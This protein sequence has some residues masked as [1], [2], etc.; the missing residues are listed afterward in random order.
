M[1]EFGQTGSTQSSLQTPLSG[2]LSSSARPVEYPPPASSDL[3]LDTNG[4]LFRPATTPLASV[5]GVPQISI[6]H[7]RN[8]QVLSYSP[9]NHKLLAV[10]L[11][12]H[13]NEH[14][15]LVWDTERLKA[16]S[17]PIDPSK[18]LRDSSH[19][20]LDR[21]LVEFSDPLEARSD[22]PVGVY[23]FQ[24]SVSS[25]AWLASSQSQL[26]VGGLAAS[27]R[28]LH[29]YDI[30]QT[31]HVTRFETSAVFGL[32]ADPFDPY[33]FASHSSQGD[34]QIWDIRYGLRGVL[35][36]PLLSEG[37]STMRKIA[38]SPHRRGVL[39]SLGTD[40]DSIRLNC[41]QTMAL[42]L[43]GTLENPASSAGPSVDTFLWRTRHIRTDPPAPLA[44]FTW[45]PHLTPFAH[46]YRILTVN[47][48][49]HLE[50]R[51]IEELPRVAWDPHGS[52]AVADEQFSKIFDLQAPP[53]A[54]GL[55][56]AAS[57]MTLGQRWDM[58][59][60]P[61][62]TRDNRLISILEADVSM[63]M[64]RRAEQGYAMDPATNLKLIAHDRPLREAWSWIQDAV[65]LAEDS[66]FIAGNIRLGF[67]GIQKVLRELNKR[68][69]M[70][71]K[72]KQQQ[73]QLQHA[74]YDMTGGGPGGGGEDPIY[75]GS[76]LDIPRKLALRIS[77]CHFSQSRLEE[78]LLTMEKA[79]EFEKAAAWALFHNC[80]ERCVV[81]LSKSGIIA[82]A[83]SAHA[84]RV[85]DRSNQ[86]Y[87]DEWKQMNRRFMKSTDNSYLRAI[88]KYYYSED[89]SD[90]LNEQG[91]SMKERLSIALRFLDD[92][93]L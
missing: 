61:L 38:F 73:Q 9:H 54:E 69:V 32:T 31:R 79:G 45:I 14:G 59:N 44:T 56:A 8:C 40:N 66:D 57:G 3:D 23:S 62:T 87:M 15:L 46:R 72:N 29:L 39:A 60:R 49:G 83:L 43:D 47:S 53:P 91:L 33:R 68:D 93:K 77:G 30:R 36:I 58:W 5:G 85:V 11:E 89:W 22:R 12:R 84:S 48:S 21:P 82:M 78:T 25:V 24:E 26:L 88:F 63:V 2:S 52:L 34:I 6:T 20:S 27:Q 81:A 4:S 13:R 10:G 67:M 80:R 86:T 70:A 41:L 74:D 35:Q 55:P 76:E 65:N 16:A 71:L 92:N 1:S 51:K 28:I 50:S 19:S 75:P 7:G 37:K 18:A 42:P 90:V 17:S 64:K